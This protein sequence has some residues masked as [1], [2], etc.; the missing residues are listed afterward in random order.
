M[1]TALPRLTYQPGDDSCILGRYVSNAHLKAALAQRKYEVRMDDTKPYRQVKW[2]KRHLNGQ[3][4]WGPKAQDLV[5]DPDNAPFK[6]YSWITIIHLAELFGENDMPCWITLSAD[7]ELWIGRY[8][9]VFN[10]ENVSAT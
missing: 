8:R 3:S 5:W 4:L 1:S 9:S 6:Q 7:E 10:H 2:E